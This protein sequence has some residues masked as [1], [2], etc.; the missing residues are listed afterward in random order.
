MS[1]SLVVSNK[2]GRFRQ[3]AHES[4]LG[5]GYEQVH[6]CLDFVLV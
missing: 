2:N 6:I 3:N 4:I 5:L 1:D